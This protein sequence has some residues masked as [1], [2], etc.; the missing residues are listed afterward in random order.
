MKRDSRHVKKDLDNESE[1]SFKLTLT[2]NII[3]APTH[4]KYTLQ[5]T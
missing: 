1:S 2:T 5:K 3:K 4:K